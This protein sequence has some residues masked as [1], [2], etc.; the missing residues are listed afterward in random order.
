M[1]SLLT[2]DLSLIYLLKRSELE[3]NVNWILQETEVS[4]SRKL[5]ITFAIISIHSDKA[6]VTLLP[7]DVV[8]YYSFRWKS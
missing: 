7:V 2:M 5:S 3:H 1:Y 8:T 4:F 6:R